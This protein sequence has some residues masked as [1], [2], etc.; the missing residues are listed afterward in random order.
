MPRKTSKTSEYKSP[1]YI[2][3]IKYIKFKNIFL[4]IEIFSFIIN[5]RNE[6]INDI[7]NDS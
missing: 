7:T 5:N 6:Q 1:F 4:K 3:I 2:F